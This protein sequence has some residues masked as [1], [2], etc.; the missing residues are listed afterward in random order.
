MGRAWYAEKPRRLNDISRRRWKALVVKQNTRFKGSTARYDSA[1]IVL[2]TRMHR[3]YQ[4]ILT[5]DLKKLRDIWAKG[6]DINAPLEGYGFTNMITPFQVACESAIDEGTEIVCWMLK[7]GGNP[8][9]L[10]K[11]YGNH[12]NHDNELDTLLKLNIANQHQPVIDILKK[13]MNNS[14][15]SS[16]RLDNFEYL[17][18]RQNKRE[19]SDNVDDLRIRENDEE[20]KRQKTN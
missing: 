4:M 10:N 11:S 17:N 20:S 1:Q 6:I 5:K 2:A 13:Y 12:G 16:D 18:L 3:L 14:L 8:Y 19:C 9:L 15:S 7:I